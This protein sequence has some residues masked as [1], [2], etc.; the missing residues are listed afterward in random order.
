[1]NIARRAPVSETL[2]DKVSMWLQQAALNGEGLETL[3]QGFCERLAAAGMP[4]IRVHLSFSVLHPLY[5][6]LGFTWMRGQGTT[7]EGYR[8][9]RE[10][11]DN[12]RFL[13]SPY[14]YLLSHNLGHM[15]RHISA[16]TPNEFP[17]F[18]QL[19]EIGV[20]DYIAFVQSFAKDANQGMIGSWATDQPG[21]FDDSII[22]ALLRIQ[23]N[24]AVAAKMA[25]LGK[26]ANNMLTTY[27]GGNAGQRVLSGQIRRGDGESIRAALVMVDMRDS[28][29][30]A[31][32][33]GRQVYIDTLNQFFDAVA[34]PFNRNGGEILS[35]V[36][37]GFLA[38][39]P[40][41]RHREP[42]ECAAQ[43]AMTAAR[44]AVM[45]M[46][47]LNRH[48]TQKGIAEVR[49]GIGLHMGN[50]MFGNVGLKD[51]LTFSAFGSAVN[52]VHR[53]QGLT[54]K[55]GKPVLASGAFVN[56]CGGSWQSLGEEQLRG[57][58]QKVKVLE[59][60][61]EH[62]HLDHEEVLE[63][64]ALEARSEAEKVM[65]LYRNTKP[66]LPRDQWERLLP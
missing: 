54:K 41:G 40:C 13:K 5:D 27:L 46:I 8:A 55:Y 12:D 50:V 29:L 39:Y 37:D 9:E 66:D 7:V 65:L 3:V 20:T 42:S 60:T 26:L 36:G 2:L 53:L 49:Y 14:Y 61:A 48:R 35:F 28:T 30:L 63:S 57:V 4:L 38:I 23:S 64:Q 21:G 15:R 52:E 11:D 25:V 43:A 10:S 31:E 34:T 32:R 17:V 18:E 24:L 59:P 6:A 19:K 58:R 1:M 33:E 22:N 56:Y 16:D 44:Q 47:E 51:R 45:R 62:L